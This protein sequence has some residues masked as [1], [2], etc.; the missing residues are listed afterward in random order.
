MADYMKAD[1]S[2]ETITVKNFAHAQKLVGG[3]VEIVH[4]YTGEGHG[5]FNYGRG[6]GTRFA[7][8]LTTSDRFLVELG[9]LQGEPTVAE[10]LKTTAGK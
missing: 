3:L 1:G 4:S 6:D 2:V 10:F 7:E 5:F 9:Y 8:V